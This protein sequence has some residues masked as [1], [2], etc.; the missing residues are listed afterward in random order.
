M[1]HLLTYNSIYNTE[2]V[3]YNKQGAEFNVT[4]SAYT[5]TFFRK[6]KNIESKK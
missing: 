2:Q 3:H 5:G 6:Q 1:S 4:K